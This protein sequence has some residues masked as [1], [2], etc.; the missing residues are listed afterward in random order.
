M[1]GVESQNEMA[2]HI[3]LDLKQEGGQ[4]R[5]WNSKAKLINVKIIK[6]WL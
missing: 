6:S 1:M 2:K 3:G 5:Q 4:K